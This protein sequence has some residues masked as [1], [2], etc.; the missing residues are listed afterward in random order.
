MEPTIVSYNVNNCA[1]VKLITSKWD[2]IANKDYFEIKDNHLIRSCLVI[3]KCKG[4]CKKKKIERKN[5]R[6]EK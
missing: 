1:S 5:G 2:V 6:K 4:K 3:R